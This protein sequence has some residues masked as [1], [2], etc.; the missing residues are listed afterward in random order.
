M[1][2]YKTLGTIAASSVYWL[3]QNMSLT[4]LQWGLSTVLPLACLFAVH[5]ISRHFFS[6]IW[7]AAKLLLAGLV[8]IHI[9]DLMET[10]LE[11]VM[12]TESMSMLF[13]IPTESV[14]FGLVR[15]QARR[16]IAGICPS[17]AAA[18]SETPSLLPDDIPAPPMGWVEWMSDTMQ[19]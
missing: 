7:F 9:R 2:A 17:C 12:T 18:F 1:S 11:S 19:T 13:G 14:G 8:Y 3:T 16:A 5:I 10:S 4:T 15:M 6:I